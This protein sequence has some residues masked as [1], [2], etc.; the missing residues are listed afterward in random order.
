MP[1]IVQDLNGSKA[2]PSQVRACPS[3]Y[4][5]FESDVVKKVP[6]NKVRESQEFPDL[7]QISGEPG[8]EGF[9]IAW[10]VSAVF[11]H[12][13]FL[14][15][16][17]RKELKISK[18]REMLAFIESP[19]AERLGEPHLQ[20]VL[21]LVRTGL[22]RQLWEMDARV[23]RGDVEGELGDMESAEHTELELQY[24]ILC[25]VFRLEAF[26]R[27]LGSDFVVLVTANLRS[28]D[29]GER[30]EAANFL[31]LYVT[32]CP[33]QR[34][35]LLELLVT[36]LDEMAEAYA[37]PCVATL[38]GLLEN[39]APDIRTIAVEHVMP[40]LG[41]PGLAFYADVLLQ[42]LYEHAVDRKF[43]ELLAATMVRNFPLT[44]RK[45]RVTFLDMIEDLAT[46]V[47]PRLIRR[48]LGLL[49][50]LI[51]GEDTE[52]SKRALQVMKSPRLAT[53]VTSVGIEEAEPMLE[54]LFIGSCRSEQTP[55][56]IS[57]LEALNFVIRRR[58]RLVK[59]FGMK[60]RDR[61]SDVRETWMS[62]AK[63]ANHCGFSADSLVSDPM[64]VRIASTDK[65]AIAYILARCDA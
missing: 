4:D 43:R 8:V 25:G 42:W 10:T 28:A 9:D 60:F 26:R 21:D 1:A 52:A 14:Q 18:L 20:E 16:S 54:A 57:C 49:A 12:E 36:M 32:Q 63:A 5:A 33:S 27:M 17:P 38:L 34:T 47:P 23:L 19:A 6:L 15:P 45:S 44:N 65:Q 62:I 29:A 24:R 53:W 46:S 37:S 51:A 2:H 64:A 41:N 31:L 56:L 30:K 58:D 3:I 40:L 7:A 59:D 11:C 61:I 35:P 39:L 50:S 22:I 48:L 55:A 13:R